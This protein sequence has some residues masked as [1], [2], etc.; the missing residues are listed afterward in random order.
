M[1]QQTDDALQITQDFR[2][3]ECGSGLKILMS[4][5]GAR[6]IC[7]IN[8]RHV[9]Y[10]AIETPA[11]LSDREL[12]VRIEERQEQ[13]SPMVRNENFSII[14]AEV[15]NRFRLTEGE[16]SVFTAHCSRLGLDPFL[17]M[18]APLTYKD[19]QHGGPRTVIPFI[20]EKGWA[21]LAQKTEPNEFMG[22]P[23][24]RPIFGEERGAWGYGEGDIVYE[25]KG[26]K[27]SW[28]E[29]GGSVVTAV[30]VADQAKANRNSPAAA[31]PHHFCRVR[32]TRRW[33]EQNFPGATTLVSNASVELPTEIIEAI[34]GEYRILDAP[35]QRQVGSGRQQGP[36]SP[37]RSRG[38]DSD[39]ITDSQRT[40]ILK[41][42][43][44]AWGWNEEDLVRDKLDDAPL[45]ALTKT[46]AS[47]LIE[48]LKA[49]TSQGE[50]QGSFRG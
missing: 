28:P 19:L 46:Q 24:L 18:I 45:D 40:Y 20:T 13:L 41:L 9:G 21:A 38:S 26:R 43:R 3:A 30:T 35:P 14:V 10:K 16:A 12:A 29:S 49:D 4:D 33:Y 15:G 31:D 8:P 1:Q 2:C 47:A 25:A 5:D 32:A 42:V 23:S 50:Q 11:E 22:P 17:A 7:T 37:D 34:E 36:S 44:E 48:Q 6:A 39:A 27:R